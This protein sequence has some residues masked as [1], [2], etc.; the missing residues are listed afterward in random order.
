MPDLGRLGAVIPA[1]YRLAGRFFGKKRGMRQKSRRK[2]EL[3][4]VTGAALEV[5]NMPIYAVRP[6]P[7]LHGEAQVNTSK[8]AVLPIMAAALLCHEPVTLRQVP[9]LTNVDSMAAV[10]TACGA[11]PSAAWTYARS[12]IRAFPPICRRP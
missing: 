5:L 11:R 2:L 4:V 8:N 3:S 7:S 9:S 6:S 12:P 10:L 1:F